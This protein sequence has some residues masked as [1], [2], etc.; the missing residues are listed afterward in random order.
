MSWY[1]AFMKSEEET[2]GTTIKR[3]AMTIMNDASA[4]MMAVTEAA[5]QI[6]ALLPKND[7]VKAV[8]TTDPEILAKVGEIMDTAVEAAGGD[9]KALF[10]VTAALSKKVP[11]GSRRLRLLCGAY[12]RQKVI[13]AAAIDLFEMLTGDADAAAVDAGQRIQETVTLCGGPAFEADVLEALSVK[14]EVSTM[15]LEKYRDAFLV[16]SLGGRE[17]SRLFPNGCPTQ[18]LTDIAGVLKKEALPWKKKAAL[19][20]AAKTIARQGLKGKDA[21]S[22]AVRIL[23]QEAKKA[24]PLPI[25]SWHIPSTKIDHKAA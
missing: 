3:G 19:L 12:R 20:H 18:I 24:K 16:A 22:L 15:T 14:L 6:L 17:L 8:G 11:F 4:E 1:I 5:E 10:A 21:S 2:G 9:A 25:P 13:D 7:E 23:A